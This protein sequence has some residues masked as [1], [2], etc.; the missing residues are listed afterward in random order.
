[1]DGAGGENVHIG[2]GIGRSIGLSQAAADL[3]EERLLRAGP[4]QL[5]LAG[6]VADALGCEVVEHDDIRAG[7]NSR[8]RLLETA[9]FDLDFCREA[10]CRLGCVHGAGDSRRDGLD[11]GRGGTPVRGGAVVGAGPD[12]VILEHGHG[13]QVVAVGVGAADEEAVF[14]D[15]AEAGGCLAG[16]G[17]CALPAVGAQGGHERGAL[18]CD[19]GAAGEDVEGDALAEED[20]ADG[21]ADGGALFD[22]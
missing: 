20:L 17:E 4:L 1:M 15:D 2:T 21:A 14:L 12:V 7:A 10:A 6:G 3:D 11:V 13:A 19:A 22:R 18:G 5:E 16:A 8:V 9:D